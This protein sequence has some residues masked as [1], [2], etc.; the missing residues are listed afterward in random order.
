VI[1]GPVEATATGNVL[2][3]AIALGHLKDLEELRSV[4]R[5]S[6]EVTTFKPQDTE[7]W[8]QAYGRF[9]KLA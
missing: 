8:T 6:F 3:Q 5:A 4:V 7:V 9:Q 1:A 2:I